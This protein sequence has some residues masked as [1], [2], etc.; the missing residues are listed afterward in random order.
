L[1]GCIWGAIGSD[2]R[3][4]AARRVMTDNRFRRRAGIDG[5]GGKLTDT[6]AGGTSLV[7]KGCGVM[8]ECV[9]EGNG[10]YADE[11]HEH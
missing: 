7:A 6:Y 1:I 9:R 4:V 2:D 8:R 3:C 11:Q 10:L 5:R